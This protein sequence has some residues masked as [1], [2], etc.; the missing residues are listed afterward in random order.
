G[1]RADDMSS[2]Q[3]LGKR[4]QNKNRPLK[5]TLKN[6]SQKFQFL[7]K[8]E[9]L[10]KNNDLMHTFKSKIY[11]NADNSFLVQKE[12]YRLRQKLKDLKREKPLLS[13]YIRSG[14]LYHAGKEI[15]RVNV[16][17]QLF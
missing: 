16:K 13:S 2:F 14:V 9:S 1:I 8:R 6:S 15:D 5:V 10:S 3:R 7:N 17:N 11:V 12:E 4:Q